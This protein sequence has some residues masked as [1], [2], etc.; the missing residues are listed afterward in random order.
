[1]ESKLISYDG[2]TLR[3][4]EP[5]CGE[6]EQDEPGT[7]QGNWFPL[8]NPRQHEDDD[9]AL[10]HDNFDPRIPVMSVGNSVEGL[11]SAPYRF[12]ASASGKVNR[13]FKDV[14]PNG[15]VYCYESLTSRYS[16]DPVGI[17]LI[18]LT[19]ATG[20]RI[21]KQDAKSCGSGPWVFGSNYADF[22]R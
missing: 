4:I 2:Q 10:V 5:L 20:L 17:V 15:G 7:A 12:N 22:E 16:R 9:I 1:M 18:Q 21:E 14:T 13:D 11:H 3:T 8:G 6:V 19:S